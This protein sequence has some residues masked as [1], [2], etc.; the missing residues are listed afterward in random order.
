M[1]LYA[2]VCVS[3][4]VCVFVCDCLRERERVRVVTVVL[5]WKRDK[6][7]AD[8]KDKRLFINFRKTVNLCLLHYF[9][10]PRGP[11]L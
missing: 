10:P 6:R 11:S 5:M 8:T 1:C 9:T 2:C 3:L 4:C 7:Q